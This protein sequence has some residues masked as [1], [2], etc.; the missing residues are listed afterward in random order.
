MSDDI[1]AIIENLENSEK[2]Y[3]LLLSVLEKEKKAALSSA[4]DL[5]SSAVEEKE[6]L[7]AE[8]RR[9]ERGR[10][11]LINRISAAWNIPEEQLRLS[12][13]AERTHAAQAAQIRRLSLSLRALVQENKKSNDENRLLVRHCLHIVNS[14]LGFFHHWILPTD[15][16]GA[17]GRM[18][19]HNNSGK[20]VSGAV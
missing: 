2:L 14:A 13:L 9:L 17:S 1:E 18:N 5:L 3:R 10:R 12:L 15:S 8:L 20:L 19:M 16:Y 6:A 11:L 4:P 7:M